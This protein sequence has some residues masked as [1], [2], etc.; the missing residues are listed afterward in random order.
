M[1]KPK[2]E[3]LGEIVI[4]NDLI[5]ESGQTLGDLLDDIA[6]QEYLIGKS[7]AKNNIPLEDE[8]SGVYMDGYNSVIKQ[9]NNNAKNK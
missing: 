4:P 2:Y 7:D 3:V 9:I 1:K 5:L 8:P 6:N